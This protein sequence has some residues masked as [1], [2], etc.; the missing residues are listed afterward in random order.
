[1]RCGGRY[2]R[3]YQGVRPRL[4]VSSIHTSH[5]T[6]QLT[7]H[8][9]TPRLTST[10]QVRVADLVDVAEDGLLRSVRR[11]L[12]RKHGW[13]AGVAWRKGG[14][15]ALAARKAARSS[16]PT[17]GAKAWGV[18]CVYSLELSQ[19]AQGKGTLC[20]RFGTACFATGAFGFAAAGQ[21]VSVLARGAKV[22]KRPKILPPKE[23]PTQQ[24]TSQQLPRQPPTPPPPPPPPRSVV[25]MQAMR[26]T[27]A[28]ASMEGAAG[29][30][31]EVNAFGSLCVPCDNEGG[32]E[33]TSSA[34][35]RLLYDSHCH[36]ITQAGALLESSTCGGLCLMSTG[37]T[38]WVAAA[39]ATGVGVQTAA[40]GVQTTEA[41]AG[42]TVPVGG[43]R[44][45]LGVHPWFVHLQSAGWEA[46]LRE[47]LVAH[48][49]ASVGEA[50]IDRAR[51]N[52]PWEDQLAAFSFQLGLASELS[53]PLI[54]HAVRADGAL[55]DVLR[56]AASARALPP[57]LVMHA[58][59]G[60]AETA[61]ALVRLGSSANSRVY[62]GFS[63]RATKLRRSQAVIQAAPADRLLIESDEH[64]AEAACRA[65]AEACHRLAAARGWSVDEAAER[66][67]HNARAAFE[68][69]A[70]VDIVKL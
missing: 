17:G 57:V 48:P 62:F 47:A 44:Y 13:P 6:P 22:P 55:L 26:D 51:L 25:Q 2:V 21:L 40:S 27:S 53:R 58:Y 15:Q 52:S 34:P 64:T 18:P 39:Q 30:T 24:Q 28:G 41:Q 35:S 4:A 19:A 23:R 60:S 9:T 1:M 3:P 43:A 8:L 67:A 66:T 5:L 65:V 50:G 20:D 56:V 45:A 63:P 70:W 59:G 69:T 14:G 11:E 36:A 54:V 38:D 12:R 37:E 16:K 49:S 68:P 10:T 61:S 29:G 42:G 31:S 32:H 46:R 33:V 7:S